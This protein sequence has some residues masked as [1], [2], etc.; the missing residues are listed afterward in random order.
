MRNLQYPFALLLLLL[1]NGASAQTY[2][3]QYSHDAAGNRTS[4]TYQ[5]NS[6][7][8]NGSAERIDTLK[9]EGLGD[10]FQDN[11]EEDSLSSSLWQS[12]KQKD[13]IKYGPL[14]K[15]QA[16][17]DAYD[18]LMVAEAMKVVPFKAQEGASL[19]S[20]TSY[21]V[22][23]IPLQY[24]VSGSGARTYSIPIFTAPDIKYAPSLSLVY[25]SQGGYGYGG[26]GWDLAGLSSIRLVGKSLYWDGEIKA[27]N[28][29]DT[30]GVFCLDGVRLVTND[31]PATNA[32]YPLVTATGHILA[33][34]HRDASGYIK[35]FTVLIPDGTVAEY[36]VPQSF[37]CT[38]PVYPVTRTT[39]ISG[40]K[41]EY[42]YWYDGIDTLA[43]SPAID[44]IDYG[45]DASGRPAGSI[46]FGMA[47]S[48]IYAYY[49]GKRVQRSARM[50][51]LVSFS[52]NKVLYS[53]H[54]SYEQGGDADLLKT[55]TLTNSSG[56]QLPPLE[57]AYGA[58]N[59]PHSGPDS[60]QV[61][62]S[63][64]TANLSTLECVDGFVLR[65]GKFVLGSHNDGLIAYADFPVYK[66]VNA[67]QFINGYR[68]DLPIEFI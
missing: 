29:S 8:K 10:G 68:S 5:A 52:G 39:N 6:G 51:S 17:K 25:N 56:E 36:S 53:Y 20:S 12:H 32:T 38:M 16:E 41:I 31:D 47:H 11:A 44:R 50:T 14:M 60:L 55:I 62:N 23:E 26:Y 59:P 46:R 18:S 13:T 7:A 61:T 2:R 30:S 40:E 27:A 54:F 58:D 35:S 37:H 34:P 67:D 3:Y 57:F 45:F 48:S 49:A 4:R 65:R 28:A 43:V 22:G 64:S 63:I 1:C 33:A 15:T 21:S 66:Q 9:V 19:R 42:S 24:G